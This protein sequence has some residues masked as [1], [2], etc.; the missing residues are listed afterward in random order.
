MWARRV[1]RLTVSSNWRSSAVRSR[2]FGSPSSRA[3]R[4][5]STSASARSPPSLAR[6]SRPAAA[7]SVPDPQRR[8]HHGLGVVQQRAA[9]V[10]GQQPRP[11]AVAQRQPRAGQRARGRHP[12]GLQRL[13]DPRRRQRV[14]AHQLAARDHGL[15]DLAQRVGQQDQVHERRRLL[16]RL[17]QAVGRLVVQGVHALEHEHPPRGLERRPARGVDHGLGH[18]GAAHHVRAG[19]PH[20]RQVRVGARVDPVADA[21]G[22]GRALGQQLGG[23]RPRGLAL[24]H[25]RGPVEE[26]R[27][28]GAGLQRGHQAH[29][30]VRVV[31]GAG[32]HERHR[33]AP[34][35]AAST[36][37]CTACGSRA[38]S[39]RTKR[40]GS[41]S[42]RPP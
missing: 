41:A 34:R 26:V 35:T 38:A 29:A 14:E 25:A 5:A 12:L 7:S 32:Q 28:R 21:V 27:V 42:A 4:A 2:P 10:G 24:A 37:A 3:L 33:P 30:R 19:G 6:A 9:L 20:P 16:Q 1:S 17:E 36:S 40:P 39:T 11:L 22:V 18:V 13:R 8:P 31:L 23:E 15:H